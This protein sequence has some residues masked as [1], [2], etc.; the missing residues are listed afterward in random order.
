VWRRQLRLRR[1]DGADGSGEG[2]G[3]GNSKAHRGFVEEQSF[4]GLATWYEGFILIS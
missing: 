4:L 2:E 3:G 1:Y